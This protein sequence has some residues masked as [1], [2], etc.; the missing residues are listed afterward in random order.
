MGETVQRL[1]QA[2][3]QQDELAQL[4]QRH[5]AQQTNADQLEVARALKA[6]HDAIKGPPAT[7]E[8]PFPEFTHPDLVVSSA[9]GIAASARDG[10]HLAAEQHIA[11]T[12]G[13]DVALA[14]GRSL[15]A[16]VRQIW[17]VFAQAGIALI[18]GTGKVRIQAQQDDIELIARRVV[19]IISTTDTIR[20]TAAKRIELKVEGTAVTLGPDGFTVH[21]NGNCHL[22]GAD[23]Q[24]LGPEAPPVVLP[25]L[26][27]GELTSE[28]VAFVDHTTGQPMAEFPYRLDAGAG[29]MAEGISDARGYSA[30]VLAPT[31]APVRV[32][33]TAR[34]DQPDTHHVERRDVLDQPL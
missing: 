13:K 19:E 23:I 33:T 9:A 18:A 27:T 4:A 16:S 20:M 22:H 30:E 6:Q 1:A 5:D 34:Q 32:T 21:S 25:A 2:G 26:P 10:I 7:P 12:S 8:T 24:T 15:F 28:W 3:A 31:S 17:S 14:V 11:L 29:R